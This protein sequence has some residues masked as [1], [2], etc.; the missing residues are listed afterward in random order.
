MAYVFQEFPQHLYKDGA[1]KV[2]KDAAERDQCVKEGWSASA[3][4]KPAPPPAKPVAEPKPDVEPPAK[5]VPPAPPVKAPVPPIR[6][7]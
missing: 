6:K 5:P 7:P 3:V 4:E 1:T 2:V